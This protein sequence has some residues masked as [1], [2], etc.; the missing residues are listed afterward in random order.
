M[1][2]DYGGE[3]FISIKADTLS[4]IHIPIIFHTSIK[5]E[6]NATV[7]YGHLRTWH[8]RDAG[9]ILYRIKLCSR[10]VSA[11]EKHKS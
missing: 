6:L 9:K 10:V 2:G 4:Y 3:D 7:E 8:I 11:F 1:L 5:T